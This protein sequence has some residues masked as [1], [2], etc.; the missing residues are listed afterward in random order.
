MMD[1]LE[2]ILLWDR[3]LLGAFPSDKRLKGLSTPSRGEWVYSRTSD[4]SWRLRV[5]VTNRYQIY[6]RM[7]QQQIS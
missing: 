4:A 7:S 5:I 6:P 1:C 3:K 2:S